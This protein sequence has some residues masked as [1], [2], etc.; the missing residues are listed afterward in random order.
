MLTVGNSAAGVESLLGDGLLSCPGCGGR[1][2]G[3]GHAVRRRVFTAGRVPVAV[4]PRRARCSSCGATHVL[5]PAW[6]L[7]RRCDGTAVIG[8]MLARAARGQGFRSIAAASGVPEDTVRDRLRRFRG[9]AGRVREFFT[10]LA[11]VLAVDPV[12][13]DPAGSVAGDAVVAVGAA[14]AAAA[15]RW[16]AL[17]V[18]AWE[19]AAVVTMG[20]LLSPSVAFRPVR[21]DVL[22]SALG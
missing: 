15:V 16:P 20:S 9:S 7:A 2:G 1:L 18:S 14:A 17:A 5:L 22:S 4:R 19:L 6:L 8:D 13:L 21:G 12:P 11:G 10:R 3:H